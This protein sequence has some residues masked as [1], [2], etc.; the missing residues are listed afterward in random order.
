MLFFALDID[1]FTLLYTFITEL[2]S[3][4]VIGISISGIVGMGTFIS[5][6]NATMLYIIN[7][8]MARIITAGA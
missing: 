5:V 7:R 1:S 6:N 4:D 3:D 8:Q 2:V